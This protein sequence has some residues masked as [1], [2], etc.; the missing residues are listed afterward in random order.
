MRTKEVCATSRCL[1]IATI[2]SAAIAVWLPAVP[3]HAVTGSVQVIRG[4]TTTTCS[5]GSATVTA[6]T[7]PS[8]GG[9]TITQRPGGA[10]P[11]QAAALATS[12]SQNQVVIRNALIKNTGAG[13][14]VR[15]TASHLFS[16]TV[17]A[18]TAQRS[19]AIGLNAS[20]ARK[21]SSNILVLATG[22]SITKTGSYTYACTGCTD[23][24]GGAVGGGTTLSYVVPSIG[25][26]TL[27][28]I[29]IPAP[30]ASESPRNCASFGK[31]CGPG[32]TLG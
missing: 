9:V 23:G 1:I 2:V 30:S 29:P 22:N 13:A 16:S 26:T 25:S 17:V 4:G 31:G 11:A 12:G 20:F 21:N 14:T 28:T 24:I 27:N 6:V 18:S 19:Y 5:F 8:C 3:A 10:T 32:E 7:L 15:I